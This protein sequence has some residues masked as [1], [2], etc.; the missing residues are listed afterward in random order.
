MPRG[1]AGSC[2]SAVDDGPPSDS[3]GFVDRRGYG[4]Q[5]LAGPSLFTTQFG[6]LLRPVPRSAGD[7]GTDAPLVPTDEGHRNR[8]LVSLNLI[9]HDCSFFEDV[10]HTCAKD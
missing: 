9:R 10:V 6:P 2:F 1:I 7:R 4:N 3:V 8:L 5:V